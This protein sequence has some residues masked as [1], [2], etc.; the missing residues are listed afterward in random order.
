M[1]LNP[2]T[3]QRYVFS[4]IPV[5]FLKPVRADRLVERQY[6]IPENPV[7]DDR[8]INTTPGEKTMRIAPPIHR[9]DRRSQ[10]QHLPRRL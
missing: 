2:T 7:R 10:K 5:N 3:A 9:G 8:K 6:Q 4:F 1:V